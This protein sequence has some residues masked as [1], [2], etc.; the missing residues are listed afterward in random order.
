M[1]TTQQ[2]LEELEMRGDFIRRHIGPDRHQ[3]AEM[4]DY[5]GLNSLEEIIDRAVPDSII[6]KQPLAL[7]ETVSERAAITQQR[8][9]R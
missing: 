9:I 6:S 7:N 1:E 5:L 3:I 4:V 8:K 2:S